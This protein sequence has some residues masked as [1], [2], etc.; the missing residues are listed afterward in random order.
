MLV[1]K[2]WV[3]DFL[4]DVFLSCSSG[5]FTGSPWTRASPGEAS[6]PAWASSHSS[7]W[8]LL[9]C[10]LCT[11]SISE[12]HFLALRTSSIIRSPPLPGH[13]RAQVPH[14]TSWTLSEEASCLLPSPRGGDLSKNSPFLWS[15]VQ[16]IYPCCHCNLQLCD[17]FTCVFLLLPIHN[18]LCG[19]MLII[20]NA[21]APPASGWGR[22]WTML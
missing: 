2:L 15:A 13:H 5:L 10:S 1:G 6:A 22:L 4:F 9:I 16:H 7:P 12:S 8:W 17:G 14:Q 18:L 11:C 19:F 3:S 21:R 20:W